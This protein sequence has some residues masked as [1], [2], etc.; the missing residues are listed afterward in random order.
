MQQT[1]RMV[2]AVLLLS[3]GKGCGREIADSA[4]GS[5][6]WGRKRFAKGSLPARDFITNGPRAGWRGR[7]DRELFRSRLGPYASELFPW[8]MH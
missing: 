1:R 2:A 5:C 8:S 6:S 3:T 4:K 7:Y